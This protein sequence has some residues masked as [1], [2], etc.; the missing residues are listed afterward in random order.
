MQSAAVNA[1]FTVSLHLQAADVAGGSIT[2]QFDPQ[3]LELT[4]VVAGPGASENNPASRA[5]GNVMLALSRGA[6]TGPLATL[7]FKAVSPGQTAVSVLPARLLNSS[8]AEI[9]ASPG[10]LRVEITGS[11][12][13][14]SAPAGPKG[15][16]L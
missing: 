7:T 8:G 11:Q 6:G 12:A 3:K 1:N 9:L 15:A 10:G 5:G 2:I 14:G 4:N 13:A 16:G